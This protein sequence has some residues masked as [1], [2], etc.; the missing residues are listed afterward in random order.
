MCSVRAAPAGARANND[1]YMTRALVK[2]RPRCY[3]MLMIVKANGKINLALHITGTRGGLHTIDSVMHS[4]DIGDILTVTESKTVSVTMRGV[5]C[6]EE[7]NTAFRAAKAVYERYGVA[8]N[9]DIVKRIPVGGGMGGSSADA[10]GVLFCAER[11]LASRG[12]RADLSAIA[13]DTG[14]DVPFMM[15]GGCA[16][17]FG[18][19]DEMLRL[20]S[21]SFEA[22]VIDCG[23]VDTAACYGMFDKLGLPLGGSCDGVVRALAEGSAAAGENALFPAACRLNDMLAECESVAAANGLKAV[24]TGS[25]GCMFV[26]GAAESAA[27]L[28]EKAD[29]RCFR[30]RSA[31]VGVEIIDSG[32]L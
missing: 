3:N 21:C 2:K 8:L 22:L 29:M 30:V 20:M 12:V 11:I 18:T 5:K 6:P 9:A 17:V 27:A 7:R 13:A 25:G 28:F 31:S 15:R 14:S 23:A 1:E 4:V 10:A 32:G 24:M 26:L 16:R 19:G